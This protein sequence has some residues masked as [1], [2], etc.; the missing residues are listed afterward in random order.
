MD[1]SDILSAI[2]SLKNKLTS[3]PDQV[4]SFIL[5][6]CTSIFLRPLLRIFNLILRTCTFPE[7][8]KLARVRYWRTVIYR[9]Y[10]IIDKSRYCQTSLRFLN[11]FYIKHILSFIV[12]EQHVFVNGK[13]T[14]T[15]LCTFLQYTSEVTDGHGQ[16]DVLYT[17]IS[18]AFDRIDHGI[19]SGKFQDIGFSESLVRLLQS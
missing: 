4:P 6:H 3:G 10:P 19:L 16:V 9:R 12:E 13:S 7:K 11:M 14:V 5:K 17:D 8:W 15:N 2:K 1:E 18:K